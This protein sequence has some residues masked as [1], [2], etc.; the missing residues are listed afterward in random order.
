VDDLDGDGDLDILGKPFIW[1]DS[2]LEIW[3]NQGYEKKNDIQ[4][5]NP[6]VKFLARKIDG[7][8]ETWYGPFSEGSAVFDVNKD[9][10]L[11]ITA[12]SHWYQGPDFIKKPLRQADAVGEFVNNGGDHPHDVNGDG[13]TD[14]ISNGW[15]EDQNVYWYEHPGDMNGT[16]KKHLI[17]KSQKTEFLLCEDIDGDGDLDILPNHWSPSEL[18]WLEYKKG[19]FV[20]HILGSDGDRH[21]MGIG[22][23]NGDGR[24]DV[25]TREGWYEAPEQYDDE[26]W[27]WHPDYSIEFATSTPML[28]YD[29]NNDGLNDIIYGAAHDYGLFWLEQRTKKPW[30]T[31]TIDT[32]WSQVHCLVLHDI[33]ADGSLDLITGKRL[34]GHKGKDPGSS[35]PLGLYWYSIDRENATF[36]KHILAYNAMIGTGMQINVE[37]ID[38]DKDYDIVVSGKSGLYLLE[39][40][41][42]FNKSK[43]VNRL[44]FNFLR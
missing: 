34:R 3:L 23:L 30:R 15:F 32:S 14:I 39:N 25:V 10:F 20:K 7:P 8:V 31:H 9:G 2:P 36:T 4:A 12:G 19:G 33:N 22:D 40:M 42:Y 6:E 27:Q 38:N 43:Q 41:T 29:V 44:P 16:W 13:W 11:D 26:S 1:K 28:V 18:F 21:G 35:E 17:A 37:D 5:V 24:K